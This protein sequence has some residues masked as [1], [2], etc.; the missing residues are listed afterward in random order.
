MDD[1]FVEMDG[2]G[3]G[4]AETVIDAGG[5]EEARELR[6]FFRTAHV[7]LKAFVVMD[8]AGGGDELV[9]EA[10]IDDD[11]AAAVAEAGE[12]GIVGA[13]DIAILLDGLLEV[14]CEAGGCERGEVPL[15]ILQQEV[16]EPF[17]R[18]AEGAAFERR[19]CGSGKR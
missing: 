13:D 19:T 8:A 6:G 12:V 3:A 2:S 1:G 11:F 9:G 14:Q 5:E 18:D 4:A 7:L 15:R 17:E 10:V 16:L